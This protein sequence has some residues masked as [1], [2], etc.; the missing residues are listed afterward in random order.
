MGVVGREVRSKDALLGTTTPEQLAGST[1]RVSIP[2]HFS[3]RKSGESSKLVVEREREK[4]CASSCCGNG[5]GVTV[6]IYTNKV[7]AN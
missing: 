7:I 3:K 2:T 5:D 4:I 6:V 1:R